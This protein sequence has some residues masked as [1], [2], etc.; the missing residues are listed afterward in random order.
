MILFLY[1]SLSI[2][3]GILLGLQILPIAQTSTCPTFP[4]GTSP[5]SYSLKWFSSLLPFSDQIGE[6]NDCHLVLLLPPHLFIQPLVELL[7]KHQL[8]IPKV[9]WALTPPW[10]LW[11]EEYDPVGLPLFLKLFISFLYYNTLFLFHF[12]YLLFFLPP[13]KCH[14]FS[15]TY[16]HTVQTYE[17]SGLP[18]I[19]P[20][21]SLFSAAPH[22]V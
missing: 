2:I 15:I 8:W 12:Q 13:S 18:V 4:W 21:S 5:F 22:T 3:M 11:S 7:S 20:L 19:L 6:K 9:L 1:L 16:T 10:F 17:H 14:W